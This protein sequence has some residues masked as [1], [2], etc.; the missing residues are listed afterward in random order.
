MCV[1]PRLAGKHVEEGWGAR[2]GGRFGQRLD[3][4]EA[5][6]EELCP[7]GKG[8]RSVGRN[9]VGGRRISALADDS[10]RLRPYRLAWV[11]PTGWA[12]P[13][14]R[15]ARVGEQRRGCEVLG[16]MCS[17]VTPSHGHASRQHMSQLRGLG[18]RRLQGQAANTDWATVACGALCF[19]EWSVCAGSGHTQAPALSVRSPM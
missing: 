3:A 11:A 1:L 5:I 18:N 15:L 4:V 17:P 6:H 12:A 9:S 8:G 2:A 13:N 14:E 19:D 16:V 7:S 10:G